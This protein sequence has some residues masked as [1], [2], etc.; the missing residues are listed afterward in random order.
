M[1]LIWS[2]LGYL[3]RCIAL[4][5]SLVRKGPVPEDKP[6]FNLPIYLPTYLLLSNAAMNHLYFW[7]G[8]FSYGILW[9]NHTLYAGKILIWRNFDHL[10]H[11]FQ[12]PLWI[13][14]FLAWKLFFWSSLRKSYSIR[15]ESSDM[16][17]FWAFKAKIWPFLA[18]IDRFKSF[19]PITSKLPEVAFGRRLV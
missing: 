7:Y 3:H 1:P 19:W 4:M 12:T 8:I 10:S 17:K 16:A 15:Q 5:G 6:P 14:L 13:L 18:K 11:K 2:P 9:E